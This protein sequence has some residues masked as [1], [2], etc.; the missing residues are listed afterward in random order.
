METTYLPRFVPDKRKKLCID[1]FHIFYYDFIL[2]AEESAM[3][4]MDAED[5]T[6]HDQL[7]FD[8]TLE[9][10]DPFVDADSTKTAATINSTAKSTTA[11]GSS[12]RT[13]S[14]R[15]A[16]RSTR[17]AAMRALNQL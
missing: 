4:A 3:R 10:D 6:F 8:D 15:T 12:T 2:Y 9:I 5:R 17:S 13:T 14:T 16:T 7:K 11:T 1:E